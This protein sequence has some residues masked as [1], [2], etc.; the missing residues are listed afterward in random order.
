MPPPI[1]E[2][3]PPLRKIPLLCPAWP[4]FAAGEPRPKPFWWPVA[5]IWQQSLHQAAIF[6]P[7]SPPFPRELVQPWHVSCNSI[8][9]VT[10]MIW[11]VSSPRSQTLEL[12]FYVGRHPFHLLSFRELARSFALESDSRWADPRV[13]A[14]GQHRI[15]AAGHAPIFLPKQR[16]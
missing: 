6:V 3:S 14:L 5:D 11:H 13:W 10:L 2:F 12:N 7:E 4:W 15:P 16:W 9:V 1:G 8:I